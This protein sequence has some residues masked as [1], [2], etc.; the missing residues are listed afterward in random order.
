[1]TYVSSIL[2]CGQ[3]L[4]L[5]VMDC[6]QVRHIPKAQQAGVQ[7]CPNKSTD[8]ANV[9]QL[10]WL[11]AG[12]KALGYGQGGAEGFIGW[13]SAR[14]GLVTRTYPSACSFAPVVATSQ[15][16]SFTFAYI[17]FRCGPGV[18]R[19]AVPQ[20]DSRIAVELSGCRAVEL[21]CGL[22]SSWRYANLVGCKRKR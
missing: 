20:S 11:T 1:M 10:L 5:S 19:A 14:H 6:I 18:F 17:A 13:W 3:G 15:Q 16:I 22:S 21:W 4:L 9:E 8:F 2:H 12:A 7:A